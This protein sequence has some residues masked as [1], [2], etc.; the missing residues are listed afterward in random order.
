M[1]GLIQERA[2]FREFYGIL[3][4]YKYSPRKKSIFLVCLVREMSVFWRVDKTKRN[5]KRFFEF[6]KFRC[7]LGQG[8]ATRRVLLLV[9]RE[10]KLEFT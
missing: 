3:Q 2:Y 7:Y 10:G 1:E 8:T 9:T 6:I 5:M 4:T